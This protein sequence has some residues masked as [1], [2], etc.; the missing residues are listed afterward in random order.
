MAEGQSQR[1][2]RIITEVVGL[3]VQELRHHD[4]NLA[5]AG[6]TIAADNFFDPARCIFIDRQFMFS[7]LTDG[8][9]ARRPQNHRG[10]GVFA[11]KASFDHR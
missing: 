9:A 5:F 1:I 7:Q 10:V 3:D 6:M 11:V 8:G 4:G 2:G